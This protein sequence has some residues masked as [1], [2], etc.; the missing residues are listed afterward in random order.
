MK[1]GHTVV[2]DGLDELGNLIIRDPAEGTKYEMIRDDFLR[3]W[4]GLSVFRD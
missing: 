3:Y 2:V 4:S 1:L